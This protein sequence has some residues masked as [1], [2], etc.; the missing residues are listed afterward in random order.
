MHAVVVPSREVVHIGAVLILRGVTVLVRPERQLRHSHTAPMT[1]AGVLS[2]SS[3][4]HILTSSAVEPFSAFALPSGG[5]AA[6]HVA[7]GGVVQ[8]RGLV[9]HRVAEPRA[10]LGTLHQ[11]AVSAIPARGAVT[12]VG[13]GVAHSMA[14]ALQR[15]RAAGD[16][17]RDRRGHHMPTVT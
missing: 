7:A 13:R 10:P 8:V 16:P 11:P 4:G 9:G 14:G 2:R 1:I 3:T 17:L 12:A 5:V 15:A 6:A